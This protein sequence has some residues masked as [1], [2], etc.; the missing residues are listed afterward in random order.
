MWVLIPKQTPGSFLPTFGLL[1]GDLA[2]QQLPPWWQRWMW[3]P[4][5]ELYKSQVLILPMNRSSLI[6]GGARVGVMLFCVNILSTPLLWGSSSLWAVLITVHFYQNTIVFLS[7][8]LHLYQWWISQ[9]L[10]FY[11]FFTSSFWSI[12]YLQQGHHVCLFKF[13][14]SFRF[15][16][17]SCLRHNIFL[18]F[19]SDSIL[20]TLPHQRQTKN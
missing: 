12:I 8:S 5:F 17:R 6:Y 4:P 1:Y 10:I 9:D 7:N 13:Y 18:I 14:P 15:H 2:G 16:F 11:F 3:D 19:L 20:Q